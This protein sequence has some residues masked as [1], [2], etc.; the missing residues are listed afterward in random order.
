MRF[1]THAEIAKHIDEYLARKDITR[2]QE[3]MGERRSR[4][5]YCL[6]RQWITNFDANTLASEKKPAAADS[7]KGTRGASAQSGAGV[8]REEEEEFIVPADEHFTRCPVCKEVFETV[9]DEEEG[10]MMSRNAARVLVTEAADAGLYKLGRPTSQPSINY[11]IVHKLL[12]LDGW[13]EAGRADTLRRARLRYDQVMGS[14]AGADIGSALSGAAGDGED[15]D[16]V[17]VML[18]LSA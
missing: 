5:W 16:D 7:G 9:W 12:V 17:F 2:K 13:L 14:A 8:D 4:E 3:Q 18:E 15:E 1:K 6:S 10:E 11:V